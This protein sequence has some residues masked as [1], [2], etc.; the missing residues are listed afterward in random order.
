[1]KYSW[2]V[3][4]YHDDRNEACFL[5]N[6]HRLAFPSSNYASGKRALL[7]RPSLAEEGK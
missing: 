7:S 3:D 1:M 6:W 2:T 5:S 4:C